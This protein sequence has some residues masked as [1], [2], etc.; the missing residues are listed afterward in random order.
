MAKEVPLGASAVYTRIVEHANTLAAV[1]ATMPPVLSS[2]WMIGWMEMACYLAQQ[3]FCDHGETTVGTRIDVVHRAPCTVD[4]R[5]TATAELESV[6]GRFYI[7]KVEAK[8]DNGLKIGW[9][10]VHRAVVH[11]ERFTGKSKSE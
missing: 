6:Q 5:V 11:I 4:A 3:P 9:G 8:L 2:P 1:H 7:Y 10:H